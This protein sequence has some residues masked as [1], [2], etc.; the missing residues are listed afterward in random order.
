MI[1]KKKIFE[2]IC[3]LLVKSEFHLLCKPLEVVSFVSKYNSIEVRC[4]LDDSS[5]SVLLKLSE[6]ENKKTY[7]KIV[8]NAK[9]YVPASSLE[10]DRII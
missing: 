10:I 6:M 5:E 7:E 8:S 4:I 1:E 3:V 9:I 2:I